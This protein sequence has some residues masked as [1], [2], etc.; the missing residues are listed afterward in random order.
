MG[1]LPVHSPSRRTRS[2][3]RVLAAWLLLWFAAMSFT[4]P[5][6]LSVAVSG[7]AC[8]AASGEGGS[9]HAGHAGHEGH[10]AHPGHAGH[11]GHDAGPCGDGGQADAHDAHA[12]HASGSPNHCP[13]CMH[14]AVPPPPQ[15]AQ[16]PAEAAP[17][18]VPIAAPRVHP[19]VRTDVPPPARAPPLFS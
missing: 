16:G 3:G 10:A 12:G 19:R 6:P 14:A 17:A 11:A 8:P 5:A 7:E 4:V 2:I 18:E 9:A 15:F 13:L 1:K